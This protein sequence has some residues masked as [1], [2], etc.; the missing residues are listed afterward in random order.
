MLR[1][2]V[3]RHIGVKAGEVGLELPEARPFA[4]FIR[5]FGEE[6]FLV[7]NEHARPQPLKGRETMVET[8]SRRPRRIGNVAPAA[9]MPD[10]KS[11]VEG[12]SGS[13]R[14][15][16]GGSRIIKKKNKS[17]KRH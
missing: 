3:D 6:A 1:D 7:R 15:D 14:V 2:E 9:Q 10:R 16:L 5:L 17:N 8:I 12:K 13:V 4:Q 11:D